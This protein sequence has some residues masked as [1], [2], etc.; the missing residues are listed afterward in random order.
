[1][2]YSRDSYLHQIVAYDNK[3]KILLSNQ[4]ITVL[5]AEQKEEGHY[6]ISVQ[7]VGYSAP[8]F[9]PTLYKMMKCVWV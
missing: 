7:G 9:C 4:S 8:V 1:M 3:E 5:E 6:P 2:R